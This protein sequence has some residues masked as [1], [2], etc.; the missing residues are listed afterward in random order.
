MSRSADPLAGPLRGLVGDRTAKVLDKGLGLRTVGDLLDHLPRRYAERGELTD[1]AALKKDEDVTVMAQVAS[2]ASR[3][4]LKELIRAG[5][6]EA[7]LD[8]LFYLAGQGPREDA[9]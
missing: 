9:A 5:R 3:R 4:E 7:D 6:I 1:L 8:G 2:V